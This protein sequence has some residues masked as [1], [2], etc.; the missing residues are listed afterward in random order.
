M[1]NTT[2]KE[3]YN[4]IFVCDNWIQ[5]MIASR[6]SAIVCNCENRKFAAVR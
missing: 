3:T 2:K 6:Q 5:H 4:Q 1:V